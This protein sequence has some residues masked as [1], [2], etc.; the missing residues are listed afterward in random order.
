MKTVIHA[1]VHVHRVL[2]TVG[3]EGFLISWPTRIDP[4]IVLGVVQ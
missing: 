4:A 1:V 2:H 3:L